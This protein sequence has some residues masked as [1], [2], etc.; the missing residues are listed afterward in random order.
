MNVA[1]SG[2]SCSQL[3]LPSHGADDAV[4]SLECDAECPALGGG[5]RIENLRPRRV[6][7]SVTKAA[8]V[9]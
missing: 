4:E 9:R 1:K 2:D 6:I 3:R 7:A 8:Q 5:Q